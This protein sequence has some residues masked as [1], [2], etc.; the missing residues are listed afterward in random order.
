MPRAIVR[1]A[2]RP[3]TTKFGSWREILYYDGT[4]ESIALVHGEVSGQEEV[5]CRVHSACISAH[6]FNSIECDCREQMAASQATIQ[7]H[8]RGVVIWLDQEGRANG[9]FALM[10]ATQLSAEEGI[11]QT[12]A[13]R[14][15][16][17][18][19]DQRHYEQAT[20][21]LYDLRVTSVRLLTNSPAKAG[22]IAG[23]GIKVANLLPVAVDLERHPQ[24]RDYYRD[25]I[26]HGHI[27]D[28]P[29]GTER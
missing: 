1:L 17:Y 28:M 7:E 15:L 20:A 11:P 2:E 19:D 16:G 22:A 10:L 13:Y 3:L 29:T 27:L 8:G 12:E 24:L 6:V 14:R 5:P 23:D 9:H 25:K 4:A 21:I 26:N 18:G